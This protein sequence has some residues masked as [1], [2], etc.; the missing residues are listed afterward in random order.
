MWGLIIIIILKKIINNKEQ[1]YGNT[2]FGYIAIYTAATGGTPIL[3]GE[4]STE[5]AVSA[6][7]VVIIKAGELKI[8]MNM[9]V[10]SA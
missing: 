8:E 4:L 3:A 2:Y 6:G 7:Y 5:I 10:Q 1:N 9:P